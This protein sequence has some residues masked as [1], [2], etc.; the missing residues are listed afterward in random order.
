MKPG[1]CLAPVNVTQ[2]QMSGAA[3]EGVCHQMDWPNDKS[4]V[5]KSTVW[6]DGVEFI[7]QTFNSIEVMS[8]DVFPW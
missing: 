7:N 8:C 3:V 2:Y 4:E 6:V 5:G 1:S